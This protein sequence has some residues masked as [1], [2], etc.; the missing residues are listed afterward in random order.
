MGITSLENWRILLYRSDG[1][2]T[3]RPKSKA[4]AKRGLRD[5][6]ARKSVSVLAN[7]R[8]ELPTF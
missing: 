1:Q 4:N 5:E 6:S 7:V 3:R 8:E 2:Q